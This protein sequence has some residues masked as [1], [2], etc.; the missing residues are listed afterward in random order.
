LEQ[1]AIPLCIVTAGEDRICNSGAAARVAARAPKGRHVD[2]PGAYHEIFLE[3]DARRQVFWR[4]FD[5]IAD[6][7][8]PR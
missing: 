8:A 2:V 7:A 4:A 3:T 6:E 1:V 5:A